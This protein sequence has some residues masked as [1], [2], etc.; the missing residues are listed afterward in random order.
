MDNN[1]ASCI[2]SLIF[3]T[4]ADEQQS[5]IHPKDRGV[6][7]LRRK[8]FEQDIIRSHKVTHL[9][10]G[11]EERGEDGF[12]FPN[13]LNHV[14]KV[15]HPKEQGTHNYCLETKYMYDIVGEIKYSCERPLITKALHLCWCVVPKKHGEH[16]GAKC[17]LLGKRS[18]NVVSPPLPVP[19]R[20]PPVEGEVQPQPVPAHRG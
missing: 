6:R 19:Y 8:G 12:P 11:D 16:A 10:H 15:G 4:C 2:L 18:N 14:V 17:E 13:P 1:A 3:A 20:A 9:K 7:K 5:R